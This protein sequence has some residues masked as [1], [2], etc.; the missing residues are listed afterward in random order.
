MFE[1]VISLVIG[2][3]TPLR[4]TETGE[5]IQR[6]LKN[7]KFEWKGKPDRL[8]PDKL[9]AEGGAIMGLIIAECGA[10]LAGI[11]SG[12]MGFP[13]ARPSRSTHG[14]ILRPKTP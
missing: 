10:Y 9:L 6:R 5:A 13:P 3:N 14:S 7:V 4:L 2:S 1:A 11:E 12:G 8:L